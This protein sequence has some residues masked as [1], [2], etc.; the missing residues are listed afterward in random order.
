MT[1]FQV[2][3]PHE[4]PHYV[5]GKRRI[6]YFDKDGLDDFWAK[7]R[8]K[9]G[10]DV[11]LRNGCYIFGIST[12]RV[13]PWYV[14][15]TSKGFGNETF[16]NDKIAKISYFVNQHGTPTVFFI[17]KALKNKEGKKTKDIISELEDFLIQTTV[18]INPDLLNVKGT[19]KAQWSIRGSVRSPVIIGQPPK[20]VQSFNR[21]IGRV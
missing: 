14:G 16:T 21:M 7:C 9:C 13:F 17:Y 18:F 5:E 20:P 1:E 8:K 10:F 11:S 4:I 15:K 3:G 6:K 19:K 12:K 2:T